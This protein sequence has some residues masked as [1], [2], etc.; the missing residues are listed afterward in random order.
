MEQAD[1]EQPPAQLPKQPV[2]QQ[3]QQQAAAEQAKFPLHM[4]D[5]IPLPKLLVV[6]EN[7]SPHWR[8]QICNSHE[9]L[10]NLQVRDNRHRVA[11]FVTCIGEDALRIYNLLPFDNEAE[12]LD[13]DKVHAM[14]ESAV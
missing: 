3:A 7:I 5:R 10:S 12:K 14:M 6:K 13:I 4:Q 1:L 2:V 8:E 11:T 9:I